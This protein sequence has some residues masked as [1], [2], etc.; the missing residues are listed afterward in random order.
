MSASLKNVSS[1]PMRQRL[2]HFPD[3]ERF[4]H[5]PRFSTAYECEMNKECAHEV[6]ALRLLQELGKKEHISEAGSIMVGVVHHAQ[7]HFF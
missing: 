7:Q 5:F 2:F 4:F 3:W 6:N 1:V